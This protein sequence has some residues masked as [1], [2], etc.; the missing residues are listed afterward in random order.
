MPSSLGYDALHVKASAVGSLLLV[1]RRERG[2]HVISIRHLLRGTAIA[3]AMCTAALSGAM[4]ADADT[5]ALTTY[6]QTFFAAYN[7][8]TAED[9]LRRIPGI[10]TLLD[11]P[12]DDEAARGFGSSGSPI[13]FNGRRLSGKSNDPLAALK[14]IQ[15]RQVVRVEIIRGSVPGLDVRIGDEGLLVNVVLAETLSSSYGAWE[16]AAFYNTSGAWRFGG[17]LSYAGDYGPLSYTLAADVDPYRE[18]EH[19]R[20]RY[21]LPPGSVPVGGIR[22]TERNWSTSYTVTA[23]LTYAFANGDIANLNGRYNEQPEWSDT[24]INGFTVSPAGGEQFTGN[25]LLTGDEAGD[26]GWEIGGDYEHAFDG[27]HVLRALFVANEERWPSLSDVFRTPAGGATVHVNRQDERPRA[28]EN[29]VRGTY[30]RFIDAAR[31]LELGGEVALNAHDQVNL[32]FEDRA[33]ILTSVPLFNSAAKVSETRLESVSRYTWQITPAFYAEGAVDTEYSSLKQRGIDVNTSRSFFFAKPRLDLRYDVSPSVQL[34]GRIFRTVGQLDFGAFVSSVDSD[35][36]RIGIVQAGNPDLV[37]EKI[38]T[39]EATGEYKLPEGHGAVS[40]RG[41]YNSISDAADQVLIAPDIAGAGNIGD[42]YSYGAEAKLGVRLGWIGL[43]GASIDMTGL[44]QD[45]SVRDAF[46]GAR[47]PLQAFQNY[48][49]TVS[50]RHDIE[51]RGLAYG[52]S[53]TGEDA[54]FES[55][56]DFVQWFRPKPDASAFAEMRAFDLTLRVEAERLRSIATR[57]RL[58]YAGNRAAA[59]LVRRELRREATDAII[60]F[61]VRGTF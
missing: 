5:A 61:I 42:G 15:A 14:R 24:S 2:T 55:D 58:L 28:T 32:Q 47:R 27:G 12:D 21:F 17:K 13:L 25:T 31:S 7:A 40:L 49:W 20:D 9:L 8:I 34:R 4:G 37:P 46:T 22:L 50:F 10:Q 35:D 19:N 41:F 11:T 18:V 43:P 56:I 53:V 57:E 16:T 23:G 52:A 60:K 44:V 38:W 39:Y 30:T 29:I 33:G 3:G 51:W 48:E 6:D 36:A 26:M 59:P 1:S 45:S 54:I